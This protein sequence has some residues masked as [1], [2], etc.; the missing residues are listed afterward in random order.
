MQK[1]LI[2]KAL[3]LVLAMLVSGWA[4]APASAG[5][6]PPHCD[7]WFGTEPNPTPTP[8]PTGADDFTTLPRPTP[9]PVPLEESPDQQPS[10]AYGPCPEPTPTPVPTPTPTPPPTEPPA[11]DDPN[12]T[13]DPG[14]PVL[15][16][17]GL[18]CSL[19]GQTGFSGDA[20]ALIGLGLGL[21][22]VG[23]RR[24]A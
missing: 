10:P 23:R 6:L 2:M 22:G 19:S 1:E 17:S 20:L 18:G 9:P 7:P 13:V 15:E 3:F 12:Q 5:A 4:A 11:T 24:R 21:W 14:Q 16:G 8:P